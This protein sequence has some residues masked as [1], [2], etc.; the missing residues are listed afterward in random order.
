MLIC[1]SNDLDI[2]TRLIESSDLETKGFLYPI[3]EKLG[4]ELLENPAIDPMF[5][6]DSLTNKNSKIKGLLKEIDEVKDLDELNQYAE[7]NREMKLLEDF[8]ESE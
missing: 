8:P 7:F 1:T 3:L 5:Y 6:F 4:L 2:V